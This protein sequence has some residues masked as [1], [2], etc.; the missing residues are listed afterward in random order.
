MYTSLQGTSKCTP[1]YIEMY[2]RRVVAFLKEQA[3]FIKAS[4]YGLDVDEVVVPPSVCF[5]QA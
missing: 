5:I 1:V 2:P 3:T 4:K